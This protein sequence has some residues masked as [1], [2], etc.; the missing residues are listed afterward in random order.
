MS[1]EPHIIIVKESL[2]KH[3]D[4]INNGMWQHY[5]TKESQAD[6]K[7]R[8]GEEGQTLMEVIKEAYKNKT[9]TIRGIELCMIHPCFSSFNKAVRL[10]LDEM[11]IEYATCN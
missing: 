6:E 9:F 5:G 7:T 4:L 2:E 8:G 1:Y 10:K 11:D 3:S